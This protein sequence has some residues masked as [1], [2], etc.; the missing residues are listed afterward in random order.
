M[1]KKE[2]V[3]KVLGVSVKSVYNYYKDQKAKP[4]IALLEKYFT[5]ED[6][7][8]FLET[9]E[10]GFLEERKINENGG[11]LSK[12]YFEI[13]QMKKRISELEASNEN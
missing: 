12:I 3:A 9:G 4:I 6:L 10:I 8:E 1:L 13:G 2:V 7:E 5:Q 11:V